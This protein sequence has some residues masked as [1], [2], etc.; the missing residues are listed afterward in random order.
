M[1]RLNPRSAET[2]LLGTFWYGGTRHVYGDYAW[3][4][5]FMGGEREV[6]CWLPPLGRWRGMS[7]WS[8]NFR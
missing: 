8:Q 6:G 2:A 7:E 3:L 5:A 1:G 4:V